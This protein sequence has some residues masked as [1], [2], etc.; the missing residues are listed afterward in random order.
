MTIPNDFKYGIISPIFKFGTK[1]D[2]DNYRPVSVL[3]V[4][5]QN[6][7][8]CIHSQISQFLEEKNL[9]SQTQFGFRK[10]RKTELAATL[11]LD[12][13]RLN[14]NDGFMT[15]AIFIDLSK[16]FDTLSHS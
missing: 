12:E 5:S 13:I 4:C 6:F 14:M 1:S 2:L 3:P 15:G 10:Q 11:F 8:K 16:A 7:E 9:L